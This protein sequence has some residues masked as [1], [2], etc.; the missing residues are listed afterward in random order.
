MENNIKHPKT[1]TCK[2]CE[3]TSKTVGIAQKENHYYYVLLDT[4]QWEDFDGSESV[5]EQEFFCVNCNKKIDDFE[6]E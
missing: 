6:L 3:E 5:E 4:N 1:Y 2:F